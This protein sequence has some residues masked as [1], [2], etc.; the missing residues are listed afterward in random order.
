MTYL[1]HK[2]LHTYKRIRRFLYRL[3]K[4]DLLIEV[5]TVCKV[6]LLDQI[7][8]VAIGL[9]HQIKNRY[10]RLLVQFIFL[11]LPQ[12]NRKQVRVKT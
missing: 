6:R 9:I 12:Q 11:L 2:P 10:R 7:I 3:N 1:L 4:I 5:K 8:F